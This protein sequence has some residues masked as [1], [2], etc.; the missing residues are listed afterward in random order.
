MTNI[1][2]PSH[3]SLYS[4]H[5]GQQIHTASDFDMAERYGIE[6]SERNMQ[7]IRIIQQKI[8]AYVQRK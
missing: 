2:Q 5:N 6:A 7:L 3:C 8:K 4:A 1:R